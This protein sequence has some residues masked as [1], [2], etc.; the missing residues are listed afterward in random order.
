MP[1]LAIVNASPRMP[2][3]MMALIRLNTQAVKGV[4]LTL[5]ASVT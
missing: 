3:P 5:V 1:V 4:P 2:V